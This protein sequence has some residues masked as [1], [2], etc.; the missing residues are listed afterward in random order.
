VSV[1]EACGHENPAGASFCNACGAPLA[2]PDR[3]SER[4]KTVTVLFCDVI[5]STALGERLDPESLRRVLARYF[6]VA[7]DTVGRHGGVVEKFIGDAV[8]AVFGVPQV[9]EDDALRAVRAAEELRGALELLNEELE[10]EYGTKLAVRIG[11]NTGEVVTGTE[12]RLATGDAVNVAARL[13]QAAEPG[14]ILIGADTLG[15]VRDAVS[16]EPLEPLE[17]TGKAEAVAAYRVLALN[18]S[19]TAPAR[20]LDVP[21]VGRERQLKLLH[22]AFE[23]VVSECSCHL[24]TVLGSAGVG[25]SRL[26]SEFLRSLEGATVLRGRCLSYGEGI[27]YWP[28]VEV[29]KQAGGLELLGDEVARNALDVVLGETG[30]SATPD[31]IA[32]AFRKLLETKASELPVVCLFDDIQW[33]EDTFLDLVEHVADLSRGV[34]ILLLCMARPDLLDRRPAW[35]GGKLNATSV[36]L[37]PLSEQETGELMSRLLAGSALDEA[38]QSRVRRAAG[39]NPLFVEEMLA[40]VGESDD[41]TAVAVPPTIQ[42]LLAA[43]LDQLDPSERHVLERGSVEGEVFHRGSVAALSQDETRLDTRLTALVR[44]DLL[45]PEQAQLAGDDGYRF[46]HLLIRDAAY[47]ALP[48]ATRADLHERFASWLGQRGADLVELDEIVGYHLEQAV[49]YRS[50]LGPLTDDQRRRAQE[51]GELLARAG[52]KALERGDRRAGANLLDRATH[53]LQKP[54]SNWVLVLLDLGRCLA[55]AGDDLARSQLV[56]AEALT[57][58]E[59]LDRKDLQIR[60]RLELS[61]VATLRGASQPEEQEQLAREAIAVLERHG[62]DEGLARAWFVLATSFWVRSQW[63]TMRELLGQAIEH[64]RRLGNRSIEIEAMTFVLAATMFGSTPVEDG[65][66]VSQEILDDASDSRELQGWAVRMAG[67]FL[68][69]EGRFDEARERL[70]RARAIFTDLGNNAALVGIT[71]SAGPLEVWSGDSAAAE[72]E[73]RRGLELAQRIGDRGRVPN[74]AAGLAGAILDQGRTSDAEEYVNLARDEAHEA[75]ASAVALSRMAAARLLVR[76]GAVDDAV[77]LA[78]EAIAAVSGTQELFTLSTL[79]LDAAEVLQ[80]AGHPDEAIAALREAI[81]VSERKGATAL[82]RRA[83]ERLEQLAVSGS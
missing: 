45:R 21:M 2:A 53:L 11:V 4:R 26:V 59:D 79:L 82:V 49:R 80:L 23:H 72:R 65:L 39:G 63:D 50:E 3:S 64:A 25:K 27:T 12:E 42:A 1:C 18:A 29:V 56:L 19:A 60:A 61:F 6:D 16:V 20:R 22:D 66:R 35:S 46:R 33:G 24:F 52:R 32:W 76:T 48:K 67:T 34:P 70:A 17:L 47:E 83:N 13:E 14:E 51:A 78:Q 77:R 57:E 28:V 15:L 40:L 68:A 31:E 43:R 71:F 75:D 30:A 37:E 44:K 55:E 5:G 73:L 9:H 8:M 41:G 81:R 69:L 38:L 7:R 36:L 62:D 10:R 74:L 58:A 54:H